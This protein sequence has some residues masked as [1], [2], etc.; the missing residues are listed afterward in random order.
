LAGAAL[1][2]VSAPTLLIVGEQDEAVM[3]MNQEAM[4][5]MAAEVRLEIVRGAT[6]L[7]E[8]PGALERVA[9]LAGTW[10]DRYLTERD[11]DIA[12]NSRRRLD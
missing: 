10:F 9:D 1:A 8:E 3:A 6:H 5:D 7:F 12:R 11:D 4:R 2:R